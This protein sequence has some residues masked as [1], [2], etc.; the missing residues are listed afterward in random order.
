MP[1]L[2]LNSDGGGSVLAFSVT[3][4]VEQSLASIHLCT[5][6]R[7]P[8]PRTAAGAGSVQPRCHSQRI[9]DSS[10]DRPVHLTG[11]TLHLNS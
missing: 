9:A 3:I 1:T 6:L 11:P 5:Y 10:L 2:S 7:P 8:F 4:G